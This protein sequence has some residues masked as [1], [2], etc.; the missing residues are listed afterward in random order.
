MVGL[1][2]ECSGLKWRASLKLDA[3]SCSFVGWK[4]TENWQGSTLHIT[5]SNSPSQV[6]NCKG[7]VITVAHWQSLLTLSH[8]TLTCW[9]FVALTIITHSEYGH[10]T[11]LHGQTIN[12]DIA[13]AEFNDAFFFKFTITE[14]R[15]SH[16]QDH[17]KP[18]SWEKYH[19]WWKVIRSREITTC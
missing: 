17:T 16:R 18:R 6:S 7:P 9:R 12:K 19:V 11:P 2:P 8:C 15:S 10:R 13:H 14:S 1:V 5:L 3:Q 4:L